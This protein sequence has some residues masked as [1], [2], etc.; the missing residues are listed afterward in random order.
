MKVKTFHAARLQQKGAAT[1]VVVMVLFFIMAM[2][3][4]FANRN[5]LFEQR[6][7]SNYY[8][9]GVALEVADAGLDWALTQLNSG[10]IN[11]Q[12]LTNA[13]PVI[14]F[15][16]RYLEIDPVTRRIKPRQ[17]VGTVADCVHVHGTGWRCQCPAINTWAAAPA[18]TSAAMMQPSF[19]VSLRV[20]PADPPGIVRVQSDGCTS[21]SINQ[22]IDEDA[23][24]NASLGQ[25]KVT[26][27]FA[28]VSALKMP[29]ATP[30]T[31][32]GNVIMDASGLGLHNSDPSSNGLLLLAGGTA[33]GWV[34]ARLDSLPGSPVQQALITDDTTLRDAAAGNM[35]FAMY[36]GM[37][38]ARYKT[39]PVAR[40]VVCSANCSVELAIAYTQGVR[41][42]WIEG[43]AALSS[44]IILGTA[45]APMLLIVNGAL[46][47]TGPMQFNG[48]IYAK[49]N[50]LWTNTSA[51]LALVNGALIGEGSMTSTGTVDLW[52]QGSVINALNNVTGSFVRVPGSWFN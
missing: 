33:A 26:A 4:A 13:A 36:F 20:D 43:P 34:D 24:I 5:L 29:P 16:D 31:V 9:A 6:I 23:A 37:S 3:A 11:A 35:M 15:K 48:V 45:T 7:A 1:L 12:C 27:Q 50:I 47:L 41:V 44:N 19:Q 38:L 40:E 49:G 25:A 18:A 28:L 32:A 42:A 2:M 51:Q 30:L 52:Y 17:D 39:Q 14:S 22:C 21:S 8:R 46:T 10:A